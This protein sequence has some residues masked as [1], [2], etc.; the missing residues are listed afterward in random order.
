MQTKRTILNILSWNIKG[1]RETIDGVKMNKLKDQQFIHKL[2][3]Y[4][5][6]F[7]QETHLDNDDIGDIGL[8]GFAPGIHFLRQIRGKVQKASGRTS[9]FVKTSLRS[10]SN[11]DIVW[12]V[13]PN[14]CD[15]DTYIGSVYFPPEN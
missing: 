7:L 1:F 13:I 3:D 6:A 8:P 9:V 15:R 11:S 12:V 2:V 4:D 14:S 10:T 5:L